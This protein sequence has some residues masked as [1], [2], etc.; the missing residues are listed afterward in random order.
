MRS[1]FF[2]GFFFHVR[3]EKTK[4]SLYEEKN[5][6]IKD[7]EHIRFEFTRPVNELSEKELCTY[8]NHHTSEDAK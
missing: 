6:W 3:G 1:F 2:V 4:A 5:K 8:K 7:I